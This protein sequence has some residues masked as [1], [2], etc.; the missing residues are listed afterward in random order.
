MLTAVFNDDERGWEGGIITSYCGEFENLDK[1]GHGVKLETLCMVVSYPVPLF[2]IQTWF[3][4][5]RHRNFQNHEIED[6]VND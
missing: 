2:D 5:P 4:V 3:Y 1:K 6:G